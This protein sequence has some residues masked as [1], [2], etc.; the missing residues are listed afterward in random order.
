G[1]ARTFG[2]GIAYGSA[3]REHHLNVRA[4]EIGLDP[5]QPSHFADWLELGETARSG[6]LPR[7][8]YGDYLTRQ[9]SAA[10]NGARAKIHL[11]PH[12]AV[13]LERAAHGYR[14]V[15]DDGSSFASDRVVLAVGALPPQPLPM[16]DG[17][18]AHA[19]GYVGWPWQE[20]ALDAIAPEARVLVV[21]TGL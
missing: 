4:D 18:L 14:V 3:R 5:D 15:L 13:A 12:Q 16:L 21:G 20:G 10:V 7:E 8:V 19:P 11:H 9:L 6:F 1:D 2:R 17:E